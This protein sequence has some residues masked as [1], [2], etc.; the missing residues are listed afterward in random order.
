MIPVLNKKLDYHQITSRSMYVGRPS[1][2]GNPFPIVG[3]DT[4]EDVIAMFEIYMYLCLGIP[5]FEEALV[6][7]RQADAL[8]CWCKPQDCHADIIAEFLG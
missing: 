5:E 8:V 6:Q 7:A 2:L 3:Q 1:V 4:R